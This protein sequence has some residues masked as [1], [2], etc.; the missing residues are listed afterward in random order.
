MRVTVKPRLLNIPEV[1]ELTDVQSALRD[2]MIAKR[3]F[4]AAK[5]RDRLP[6]YTLDITGYALCCSALIHYRRAFDA[7]K[8]QDNL[9]AERL[10]ALLGDQAPIHQHLWA[11][12]NRYV[13]HKVNQ[14]EQHSATVSVA[15]RADGSATFNGI[16][17]QGSTIEIISETDILLALHLIEVIETGYLTPLA[18][19]LKA[20]IAEHCQKMSS[21]ELRAL[22]EGFAPPGSS[23]P[24]HLSNWPP[25]RR[26]EKSP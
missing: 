15:E 2:L 1:G 3:C 13:A 4:A 7:S 23:D 19:S 5:N 22:P 25:K 6:S 14:Y 17:A 8:R 18:E 11:L 10:S 20:R 24:D 12:S 16:G 21:D 9:S 26:S